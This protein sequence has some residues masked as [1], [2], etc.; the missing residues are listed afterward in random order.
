M[1][2]R[3]RHDRADREAGRRIGCPTLLLWGRRYLHTRS[4]TPLSVWQ[5]YADDV[6][7]QAFDC[8]HFLAEEEPEGP[9]PP[10]DDARTLPPSFA[11]SP[12]VL[13]YCHTQG[14][15]IPVDDSTLVDRRGDVYEFVGGPPSFALEDIH[16]AMRRGKRYIGTLEPSDVDILAKAPSNVRRM[17]LVNEHVLA[18]AASQECFY[19]RPGKTA[20]VLEPVPAAASRAPGN[21]VVRTPE[22]ETV[23]WRLVTLHKREAIR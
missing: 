2:I 17:K 22:L 1:C 8:G 20:G 3:D 9:R 23:L 19:F 13:Y 5:A 11:T 7:D 15:G 4:G 10:R 14:G 16:R 6:R 12:E 18:D 21:V